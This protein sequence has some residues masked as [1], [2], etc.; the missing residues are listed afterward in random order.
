MPLN[1][2]LFKMKKIGILFVIMA[3]VL[4]CKNEK[5]EDITVKKSTFNYMEMLDKNIR[6]QD[7]FYNYVNGRWMKTAEIPADRSRWGSF[8]ELRKNTNL[9]TIK[10]IEDAMKE[11]NYKEGSDQQKAIDYYTCILDTTQRNKEGISPIKPYLEKIDKIKNKEDVLQF[12]IETEPYLNSSFFGVYVHS[13]KKDSNKN[14]LYFHPSSS[15]LPERAYYVLDDKDSKDIREKY[16]QFIE[17]MFTYI[18][19]DENYI[20]NAKNNILAIETQLEKAKLTKEERRKPENTYHP[21][22]VVEL[23]KLIP[24]LS[25]EKY[26]SRLNL[27]VEDLVVTQ[28]EYIKAANTLIKENS[29]DAIKDYLKWNV[30]RGAAGRL[31]EQIAITDWEFYGKFLNG[32]K[33][34]RAPKERALGTVNWS[35]GETLGKLYVDKLFPPEAKKKAKE[36]VTYVQKSYQKRISKVSWMSEETKEKAI[37]KVLSLQIKIGY[38]DKWKD[39]SDLQIISTKEGGSYF[40]NSVHVGKWRFNEMIKKLA[41]PVDKTEWGMAPQIVNA[42]YNPSY[43]EIVFPAAILQPP[44]YDYKAD[45]ATNYGAMGAVIGHEISHGFDDQGAKFDKNGNFKNW[46]TDEDFKEFNK[47]GKSLTDQYSAIEVLPD[48]FVNGTFTLGENIG[49]LGGL[50]S[51]YTALELYYED[52]K[53]P[54]KVNGMTPEQQFFVSWATVWRTMSRDE[55]LKT[56]VKTDP[57]SPGYVRA[58]QPIKNMDVFYKAFDIKEGDGMYLAPEKRVKIW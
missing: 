41:K 48:V 7:D 31:S 20:S 5:K 43:N 32:E 26:L 22:N 16:S 46:W 8:D 36:M 51:A 11:S 33:E 39:F 56:Q 38:P 30:F 18:S 19:D 53:K 37:E 35:I 42:Y 55:A 17:K 34:R 13:D 23:Q 52:H 40:S 44:F 1:F 54:E 4:S 28:P 24:E 57:H 6:P 50:N 49:D 12:M 45:E 9:N 10:I 21:M 25:I 47:L 29:I 27:M 15:G 14:V 2:R 3:L 58:T